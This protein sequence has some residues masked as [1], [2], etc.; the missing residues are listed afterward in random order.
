MS[1]AAAMLAG[2]CGPT[3][4]P[5]AVASTLIVVQVVNRDGSMPD[6]DAMASVSDKVGLR[7]TG[8]GLTGVQITPQGT[9]LRISVA[10]A[11]GAAEIAPLLAAGQLRFR[12]VLDVVPDARAT[13]SPVTA[14]TAPAPEQAAVLARL[15]DAAVAAATITDPSHVD[16]GTLQRLEP[17][18]T[19][20][21]AE[22][23]VLPAAMQFAV[24]QVTCATLAGRPAGVLDDVAAQVVACEPG[25]PQKYLLDRAKVVGTD[26]SDATASRNSNGAGW[27]V[28]LV[29]NADGAR[30]WTDLTTEAV[31]NVDGA[32]HDTQP[33]ANGGSAVCQVAI[34]VDDQVVSAPAIQ[35]VLGANAQISGSFTEGTARLLADEVR[36][37]SVPYR[38]TLVSI[39][40]VSPGATHS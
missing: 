17:F 7:L 1:I 40:T 25:G 36:G 19:L 11:H 2:A 13:G 38:L 21:P 31:N 4:S 22:V 23:A 18:R 14:P 6:R 33:S 20:T 15:G 28:D 3:A 26:V 16:A 9:T 29:F 12:K 37:G 30:K 27:R 32:C 24:P 39:S 5:P 10:G 8:A 35:G 34:V